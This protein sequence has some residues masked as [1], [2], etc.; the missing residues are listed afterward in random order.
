MLKVL[1]W[2]GIALAS[3]IGLVLIVVAVLNVVG[4]NR[5]NRAPEVASTPVTAG[6]N[7]SAQL[8]RGRHLADFMGCAG[9]HGPGLSGKPFPTPS[10]LVAMS[11]P[12]LTRGAGGVGATYTAAD[13]ERALRHGVAKDGRAL[14]IMPSE[15]YTHLN[16]ADA[17]ALIAY[18]QT[19]PPVDQSFPPRKI[20]ILGG[21]LLG[22]GAVPTTPAMIAHDS[23]GKRAVVPPAVSAD[24][25][26]YLARFTGCNICHGA[27]LRGGKAAGGGGPPPGPS[28]VAFVANN[29]AEA[30]R[31]TMRTGTTPSGRKLNA[32]NMP[33]P[34]FG[35]MTDEELEAIRLYIQSTYANSAAP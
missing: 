18:L 1:K 34:Y 17:A 29:S 23:V 22:A 19:L 12:N 2:I 21:T 14:I 30:F 9:C 27:D 33:W 35:K 16:D 11:A 31:E 32:E 7:D 20:G 8:A 6:A 15:A 24:Y 5:A 4:R 28:L 13:W 26:R 25:G 3:L 10:F